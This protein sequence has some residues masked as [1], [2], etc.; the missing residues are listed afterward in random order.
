MLVFCIEGAQRQRG[1][2]QQQVQRTAKRYRG[3]VFTSPKTGDEI[4]FLTIQ[5]AK[6]MLE[7][8]MG[9]REGSRVT[10]HDL[11]NLIV[12]AEWSLI[13]GYQTINNR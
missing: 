4:C 10:D 8:K 13:L 11:D 12:D 5:G 3:K 6:Y 2:I 1:R 7:A 9:Y